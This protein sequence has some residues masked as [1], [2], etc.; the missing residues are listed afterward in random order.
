M[1][2]TERIHSRVSP[3]EL[4]AIENAAKK[5]RRTVSDFVRK[6]TLDHLDKE[7]HQP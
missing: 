5:E 3:K 4:K 7:K 6:L 1:T 2:R